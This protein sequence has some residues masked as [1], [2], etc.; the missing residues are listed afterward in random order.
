MSAEHADILLLVSELDADLQALD[1]LRPVNQRAAERITAGARD[2]LDYAALGYTIHNLYN[3]IENSFYRIA[4][5]FEN[6]LDPHTWHKDLLFRMT[7]SVE[8]IRPAV[9]SQETAD[10]LDELRSFRHVFRNKYRKQLSAD[11][12]SVLQE[13]LDHTLIEYDRSIR[14]FILLLKRL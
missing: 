8:G 6:N 12:L 10:R 3:L 1:E 2:E 13:D 7:L 9:I 4:K 5:I 11:R 14:D